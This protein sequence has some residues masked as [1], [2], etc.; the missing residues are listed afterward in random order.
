M[1]RPDERNKEKPTR[2]AGYSSD[3]T[4][5]AMRISRH[6]AP[7]DEPFV[8]RR[9]ANS[10][11]ATGKARHAERDGYFAGEAPLLLTAVVPVAKSKST[12]I[13]SKGCFNSAASA[14]EMG[15]IC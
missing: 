10:Q 12:P 14:A 2:P 5:E 1:S 15:S 11:L 4:N 13:R 6:H 8:K 9:D 7:R 3:P